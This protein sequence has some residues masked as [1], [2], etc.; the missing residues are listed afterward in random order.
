MAK[1]VAA[2]FPL[3]L[4]LQFMLKLEM[5]IDNRPT[6]CNVWIACVI[7]KVSDTALSSCLARG[8]SRSSE[9]W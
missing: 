6:G 9:P 3:D 1:N 5:I 4:E 8:K 2:K 7:C